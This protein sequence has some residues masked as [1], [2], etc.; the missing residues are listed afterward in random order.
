MATPG[1]RRIE[2]M[3]PILA[4]GMRRRE[5][6]ALLS[7]AAI[8][9]PFAAGAQQAAKLPRIAIVH[10]SNPVSELTET[11]SIPAWRALFQ[12]LRRLGYMEGQSLV[13]ERYSGEGRTER[14]AELAREVVRSKPDLI[15]TASNN[16]LQHFKAA[17]ATIPIVGSMS[18]PIAFGLVGSLARPGGNITGVS[19]DAG[20]EIW[21]KRLELLKEVLP[22]AS[23]V[24][25]LA[26]RYTWEAATGA[27]SRK[28]AGQMGMSLIG[29]PL[30]APIQDSEYQRV[31]A[32]I[33]QE[34][35]D[36]LIVSSESENFTRRRLIVELAEKD[37]LPAIHAFYESAEI[38]GLIVYA[39]DFVELWR[40]LADYINQILKGAKP[41]DIPIY[42]A[43]KYK[44]VVNMKAAKAIGLT[45]P[46]AFVL[47]ADE[48]IQ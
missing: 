29:P 5:F 10:P 38:G 44:L 41:G 13:V 36:G 24:A 33:L 25:F 47:R 16:M 15:L 43:S 19:I 8:A 21:S 48:V 42:Q 11:G 32:A 23:K 37:R 30:E 14:Y 45:I 40:H 46:P 4:A 35:A 12:E 9:G 3:A 7:G 22:S 2:R 28:A 17:T 6:I 27:V 39:S 26:S 1:Q 20:I 31:F 34:G 18:D